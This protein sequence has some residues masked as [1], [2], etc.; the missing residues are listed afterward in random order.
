MYTWN[1]GKDGK[2]TLGE[3]WKANARKDAIK[4]LRERKAR[5]S[6]TWILWNKSGIDLPCRLSHIGYVI[7]TY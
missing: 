1:Y 4:W 5:I 2:P 6:K 3:V 7:K